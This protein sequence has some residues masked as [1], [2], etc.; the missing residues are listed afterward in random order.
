MDIG[1]TSAGVLSALS[2]KVERI[3]VDYL[4]FDSWGMPVKEA[5]RVRRGHWPLRS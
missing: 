5:Y 2:K 4:P 1:E 3:I